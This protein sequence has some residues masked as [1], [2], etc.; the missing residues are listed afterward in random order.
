MRAIGNITQ[1]A[2]L[3]TLPVELRPAS[4]TNSFIIDANRF[5]SVSNNGKSTIQQN[6]D[7]DGWFQGLGVWITS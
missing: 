3:F 6:L 7:K 4:N 5:I 2:N 1:Y